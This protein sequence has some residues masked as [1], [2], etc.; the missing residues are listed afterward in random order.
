[1]KSH[2]HRPHLI[3]KSDRIECNVDQDPDQ[4]PVN[5]SGRRRSSSISIPKNRS[6]LSA[7]VLGP[8]FGPTSSQSSPITR[9]VVT[10][11]AS[12]N[13]GEPPP[14]QLDMQQWP[15]SADN[16][17]MTQHRSNKILKVFFIL[18]MLIVCIF[19][20]TFLI[21]NNIRPTVVRTPLGSIH[22][23]TIQR[24][25]KSVHEFLGIP[26]AQPPIGPLRFHKPHVVHPWNEPLKAYRMAAACP[27]YSNDR[28]ENERLE[29][30]ETTKESENCLY[31]NIWVPGD[32]LG[33]KDRAAESGK[34]AV[35]VWIHGGAFVRGS[36]NELSGATMAAF[37]HVIVVSISYRVGVLGFAYSG[38]SVHSNRTDTPVNDSG[39]SHQVPANLGL[40]DQ[41]AALRWIR[42]YI[43]CFG[44]DPERVTLMGE[45]A[46]AMSVGFHLLS[47]LS[48]HL[49]ARTIMQSG[50][51]ISPNM[52]FGLRTGP[53]KFEQLLRYT[54]CPYRPANASDSN[55]MPIFTSQ[56]FECIRKVPLA[57]Y[58]FIISFHP[59][60]FLI[61]FMTFL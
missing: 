57:K 40:Y 18:L 42:Q 58:T 44:G 56:S 29:A 13:E 43:S 47:P 30:N 24:L 15:T 23:K 61:R 34:L 19:L 39:E 27:Q 35:M 5:Q 38:E 50:S 41:V 33:Q 22:G 6:S 46:G 52:M 11:K 49:F 3:T 55:S 28:L 54:G 10:F 59:F 36:P 8:I 51:S 2:F 45:S 25:G 37:G 26:F 60:I 7:P 48:R 32:F 14:G 1:M 9:P 53:F 20:C 21:V 31:L 12:L 17:W 4:A 16:R